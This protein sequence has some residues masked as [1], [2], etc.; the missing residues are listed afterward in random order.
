VNLLSRLV[1]AG[2]PGAVVATEAVIADL[3]PGAWSLR[4][5]EPAVLRGI[6]EP[7]RAF[8]VEPRQPSD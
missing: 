6:A 3:S 2:A 4:P 8:I 7:V 5:I 1:K